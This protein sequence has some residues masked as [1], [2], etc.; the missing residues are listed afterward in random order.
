MATWKKV[1]AALAARFDATLS[2][3]A[4]EM[5]DREL[6]VWVAQAY[7]FTRTLPAKPPNAAPKAARPRKAATR[8][9]A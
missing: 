8:F 6:A 7:A 2:P 3:D 4:L 1:P 9:K 5:A